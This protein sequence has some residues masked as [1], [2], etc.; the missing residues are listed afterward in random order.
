VLRPDKTPFTV[1]REA[2]IALKRD[3]PF[4]TWPTVGGGDLRFWIAPLAQAESFADFDLKKLLPAPKRARTKL[5]FELNFGIAK[6]K[7]G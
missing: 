2:N 7:I 5:G 6:L 3:R 4:F 1:T